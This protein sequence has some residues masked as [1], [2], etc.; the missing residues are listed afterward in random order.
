[1]TRYDF[2]FSKK[3]SLRLARHL[4]F[5]LAFSL[6]F[7]I[8]NLMI[9]GPAEAKTSRSFM[10]S[11]IHSMYF[12]PFYILSTYIFIEWLLP[13]F[14]YTRKYA[15]FTIL[16]LLLFIANFTAVYYAGVLYLHQTY[17]LP[18]THISLYANKYHALVNGLFVPFML[19]GIAAG[20]KFSKKWLIQQRENEKLAKQKLATELQLLKTSIH[21][22]FLIHSLHTVEKNIDHASAQSPSL[23]LQLSDLLSYILYENDQNWVALEKELEI[24]RCYIN[25]EETS[26]G[27]KLICNRQFPENTEGKFIMPLLLLSLIESSFEY[28]F[29]TAQEE[30]LLTLT[31]Q[32]HENVL[33]FQVLFSKPVQDSSGALVPHEKFLSLQKQLKNQYPGLHHLEMASDAESISIDLKLPL[34]TRE[35]IEVKKNVIVHEIPATV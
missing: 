7:I 20:I 22:R 30:P 24:I 21:P 13:R 16:F 6:H 10:E 29:E 14:L 33:D 31:I 5:W 35:L 26:F 27:E 32:I 1:M 9:G 23:I 8:Q 12:L 3:P 17:Q 19:Y 25:L 2:I 11:T 34:Y 18:F 4:A 15:A 28:F